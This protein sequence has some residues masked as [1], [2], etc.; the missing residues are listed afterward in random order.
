MIAIDLK[1]QNL[2]NYVK[3]LGNLAVAFSGGVDSTFLLHVAHQVLADKVVA[4]TVNSALFSHTELEETRQF[5]KSRNIRHI[6]LDVDIFKI[7]HLAENPINRCYICKKALFIEI[8]KTL[9]NF[10]V[11][12]LV[13]GSNIDDDKDYRP[14]SQAISEL[15]VISPLRNADLTKQEIRTLSKRAGLLAYDKPSLA[16]LASR[17]PYGEAITA[18]KLRAVE[19]AEQFL[20]SLGFKQLRVRAH[21]NLARIEIEHEAMEY[22]MKQDVRQEIY[23]KLQLFGFQ[24]VS[25]DMLGYRMG[26]MNEN[27]GETA[28]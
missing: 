6:I 27:L 26:S 13:E 22:A 3:E 19:Q 9:A 4:V 5:T 8:L 23:S 21:N 18:E 12:Y 11:R 28:Q 17:F 15:K 16:C 14:G 1:L 25:I 10:D 2:Q 20:F 24:Y 7:P